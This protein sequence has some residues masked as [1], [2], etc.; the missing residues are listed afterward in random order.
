M[1]EVPKGLLTL[2]NTI[3]KSKFALPILVFVTFIFLLFQ[4]IPILICLGYVGI[5]SALCIL[6]SLFY[7]LFFLLNKM[8][9]YKDL[10]EKFLQSTNPL[11]AN[12][13]KILDK[14]GI[15]ILRD[16][17]K[18][19]K[20][21]QKKAYFIIE[22]GESA[23]DVRAEKYLFSWNDALGV[24]NRRFLNFLRDDHKISFGARITMSKDNKTIKVEEGKNTIRF[25]K[26]ERNV[27]MKINDGRTYD[28]ILKKEN[29]NFNVYERLVTRPTLFTQFMKKNNKPDS[30]F[31]FPLIGTSSFLV[32]A[33]NISDEMVIKDYRNFVKTKYNDIINNLGER[34]N[35]YLFSWDKIPNKDRQ[36]FL[37][38]LNDDLNISWTRPRIKKSDDGN[39][40]TVKKGNNS[41]R[42]EKHEENLKMEISDGRSYD[43]ILEEENGNLNIYEDRKKVFKN[44]YLRF[45][46]TSNLIL[47]T[48]PY[49]FSI[50]YA[51]QLF[52]SKMNRQERS[53]LLSK[54]MDVIQ[55]KVVIH[56]IRFSY[57]F[58]AAEFNQKTIDEFQNIE[59]KMVAKMGK[60]YGVE[61]NGKDYFSILLAKKDFIK[62]FEKCLRNTDLEFYKMIK[63][64]TEFDRLKNLMGYIHNLLNSS[65]TG[66]AA[67]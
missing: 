33:G 24:D 7:Y 21:L 5:T 50:D 13:L 23:P 67:V 28:Y 4:K 3:S 9:A 22:S 1:L 39:T 25:D 17:E 52:S 48:R 26:H 29:N 30:I 31:R 53:R 35:R 42:I 59:V 46:K 45:K 18:S 15:K 56:N 12:F 43:F 44:W 41:L 20:N 60:E 36:K 51:M 8:E 11:L 49:G 58:E 63:K 57:L 6:A 27:T 34:N 61:L 37:T 14:K 2:L 64:L 47:V 38:F 40:I 16:I 10:P 55:Q 62:K 19:M 66:K 32:F 65:L 54:M